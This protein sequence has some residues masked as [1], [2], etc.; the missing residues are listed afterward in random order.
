MEIATEAKREAHIDGTAW[1]AEVQKLLRNG[2]AK[3]TDN[4]ELQFSEQRLSMW[5]SE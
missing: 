5:S 2:V 4:V 3:Q 1:L